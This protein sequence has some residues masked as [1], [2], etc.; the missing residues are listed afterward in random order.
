MGTLN[1]EIDSR[2]NCGHYFLTA[3]FVS[4]KRVL[5]SVVTENEVT[6]ASDVQYR[7]SH[8]SFPLQL[9]IC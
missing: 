9:P 2:T 1:F 4:A 7:S 5:H 6:I 8:D 3:P